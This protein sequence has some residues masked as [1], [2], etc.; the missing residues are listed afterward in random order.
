MT[1]NEFNKIVD[2]AYIVKNTTDDIDSKASDLWDSTAWIKIIDKEKSEFKYIKIADLNVIT[3]TFKVLSSNDDR[4]PAPM[5]TFDWSDKETATA[6]TANFNVPKIKEDKDGVF[7]IR[8]PN[9][10]DINIAIDTE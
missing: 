10:M 5:T 3:P 4:V 6:P 1:P 2:A 9:P 8:Y 7:L